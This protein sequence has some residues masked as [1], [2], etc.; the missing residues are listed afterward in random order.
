MES[1]SFNPLNQVYVFNE[2][3]AYINKIIYANKS[4]NP[5]NQVYVFNEKIEKIERKKSRE[6][7]NPLNQ[8]YVFNSIS[9]K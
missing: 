1:V 7:F 6:S 2:V 3:I 9:P 8:V 4:F 5:L